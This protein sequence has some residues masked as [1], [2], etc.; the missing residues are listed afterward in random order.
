MGQYHKL[1]NNAIYLHQEQNSQQFYCP[2][3]LLQIKMK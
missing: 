2:E 1:S 3:T